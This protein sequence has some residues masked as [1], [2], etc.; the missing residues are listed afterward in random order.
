MSVKVSWYDEESQILHYRFDGAWTWDEYYA[1]LPL[2]REMMKE[3]QHM[4]CILNDMRNTDI[5]PTAFLDAAQ[6]VISTTPPNTGLVVF[7]ST[8]YVFQTVFRAFVRIYPHLTQLYRLESDL[9][10]AVRKQ[11]EWLKANG[12]AQD[13]L[14]PRQYPSDKGE[15]NPSDTDSDPE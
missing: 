4:V 6:S 10:E 8:N 5:V 14:P 11:R 1:V 7:V 2:G 9:Y 13:F 12:H 3:V 15:R